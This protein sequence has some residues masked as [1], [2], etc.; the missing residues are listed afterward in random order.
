MKQTLL[1]TL[2]FV[3]SS[4]LFSQNQIQLEALEGPHGLSVNDLIISGSTIYA[5][6]ND[7]GICRSDDLGNTWTLS[8]FTNRVTLLQKDDAGNVYCLSNYKL[9]RTHPNETTW[10]QLASSVDVFNVSPNGTVVYST[11]WRKVYKS[12]DYGNNFSLIIDENQLEGWPRGISYLGNNQ[13]FYFGAYGTSG[14]TYMF[15]DDGSQYTPLSFSANPSFE[16]AYKTSTGVLLLFSSYDG[17]YRST[18]GGLNWQVITMS[19]SPIRANKVLEGPDGKLWLVTG[20]SGIFSSDQDGLVWEERT[21]IDFGLNPNMLSFDEGSSNTVAGSSRCIPNVLTRST[22]NWQT[23]TALDEKF[24]TP[25]YVLD[26]HKVDQYLFATTCNGTLHST[27]D[28]ITWT[29]FTIFDSIEYTLAAPLLKAK[30]G[31]YWA[32]CSDRNLRRSDDGGA[33]W[34]EVDYVQSSWGGHF[35]SDIAESPDGSTLYVI[36]D[37]LYTSTDDGITWEKKGYA[38]LSTEI[39]VHENGTIYAIGDLHTSLVSH[40]GG[41]TFEPLTVDSNVLYYTS[42]FHITQTGTIIFS[43]NDFLSGPLN[44]YVSTD[45]GN[46]FNIKDF[47]PGANFIES[48]LL[49][50]I[51]V[52]ASNEIYVSTDQGDTWEK[53]AESPAGHIFGDIYIDED[54][55]LYAGVDYLPLHRSTTPLLEGNLLLGSAFLDDNQ[56]CI[57]DAIET[58]ANRWKI[59]AS[60]ASDTYRYT[61]AMGEFKMLLPPGGYDI[62]IIPPNALY[63]ACQPQ[64]ITISNNPDDTTTVSIGLEVTASCPYMSVDIG[65]PLLRRCFSNILTVNYCNNGTEAA[66]NAYVEVLLDPFYLFESSSIPFSMANGQLYTFPIGDVAIGECGSFQITG[67]LSCDASMGELHCF[68]A[69]IFPDVLCLPTLD[70]TAISPFCI[71]NIGAYD[72]N[73]KTAFINGMPADYDIKMNQDI[74][75]LIRFQNTGTDT[76]L[77]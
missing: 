70:T 37:N 4:F 53:I 64:M 35:I 31:T 29:T 23:Y 26:I 50:D 20:Y 34:T 58:G 11:N 13:N 40:D 16:F 49:G 43:H 75:Y 76:A 2:L 42:D 54:Q 57:K 48:N 15:S 74:E 60:G 55:Y 73:D 36:D 1:F 62:K 25:R 5:D 14:K 46:S 19:T 44:Y 67:E 71:E 68:E 27:N 66:Q 41:A 10:T 3:F 77:P 65:T 22:D 51:Y 72:P 38:S 45:G 32:V 63:E 30:N 24:K 12:T 52:K 17:T 47:P 39:H 28:G 9:F 8:F 21:D 7:K 59:K 61:E 6:I 18:D 33:T 69:H 56:N